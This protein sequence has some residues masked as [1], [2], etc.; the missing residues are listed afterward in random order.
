MSDHFEEDRFVNPIT[1]AKDSI[2]VAGIAILLFVLAVLLLCWNEQNAISSERFA[3]NEEK[4]VVSVSPKSVDPANEGR[5]VY[6]SGAAIATHMLVDLNGLISIRALRLTRDNYFYQW[7]ETRANGARRRT[8]LGIQV[9][10]AAISYEKHFENNLCS[11]HD[12]IHKEGHV[13]PPILDSFQKDQF[14]EVSIG[15]YKLSKELVK[16]I[17]EQKFSVNN[18]KL[19]PSDKKWNGKPLHLEGYYIYAG[20]DKE[21][22]QLND[23]EIFISYVPSGQTYSVIGKQHGQTLEPIILDA[24]NVVNSIVPGTVASEAI[25]KTQ[26]LHALELVWGLRFGGLCLMIISLYMIFAYITTIAQYIPA[27]AFLSSFSEVEFAFGVGTAFSAT[28]IGSVWSVLHPQAAW[29]S[30]AVAAVAVLVLFL[31]QRGKRN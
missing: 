27:L 26:N 14:S 5:L 6:L 17:P 8:L 15:A 4:Q 31:I 12:F 30:F 19:K 18:L 22:P 13:N 20:V 7:V 9:D 24:D 29:I 16:Q 28:I 23:M 11:S 3:S 2:V 25:F 21:K 10:P 1:E